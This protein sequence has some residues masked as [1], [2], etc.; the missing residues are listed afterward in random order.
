MLTMLRDGLTMIL[1]ERLGHNVFDGRGRSTILVDFGE[2]SLSLVVIRGFKRG[3]TILIT[4]GVHGDEPEGPALVAELARTIDPASLNGRLILIPVVNP[5]G[6]A[7]HTRCC[8]LDGT[9]PNR[10]FPGRLDGGVTQRIAA[11]ISQALLPHVD[12]VYDL[13]A[14][15]IHDAILPSIIIHPREDRDQMRQSLEAMLAFDAPVALLAREYGSEEMFDGEVER[16]GKIFGC[17]E[18]GSF[19][20]IGTS[21]LSI[22]RRGL[23]NLLMHLGS[24]D[25]LPD[26]TRP[27]RRLLVALDEDHI[28][29]MPDTGYFVPSVDLGA[30]VSKGDIVGEI[31]DLSRPQHAPTQL[32]AQRDGLVFI[33][34]AGGYMA[35]GRHVMTIVEEVETVETMLARG[36]QAAAAIRSPVHIGE[37]AR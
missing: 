15:G 11:A 1:P 30:E 5:L 36:L 23:R 7:A 16:Q 34:A 8:P 28:L 26:A 24:L 20:A 35:A 31:V 19:G 13:H 18:I 33:R 4:G 3:P 22:G 25:G 14:G 17:A 32:H 6:L 10:S 37:D 2:T 9:D 29:A 27:D 21:T 12:V